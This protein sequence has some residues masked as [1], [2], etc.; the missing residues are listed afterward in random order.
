M[1]RNILSASDDYRLLV[2]GCVQLLLQFYWPEKEKSRWRQ[3]WGMIRSVEKARNRKEQEQEQAV[4]E[5][6][7]RRSHRPR[8]GEWQERP[9]DS[10]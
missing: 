9:K 5:P 1:A 10:H 3:D 7:E 4:Q 6:K 8:P 2:Q